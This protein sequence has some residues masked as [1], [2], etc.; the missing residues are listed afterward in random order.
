[1]I[2]ESHKDLIFSKFWSLIAD[3]WIANHRNHIVQVCAD[4]V[5]M[6]IVLKYFYLHELPCMDA[7]R[8]ERLLNN[9]LRSQRQ[10]R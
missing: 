10:F 9:V 1:M 6:E 3:F 7:F 4:A 2:N 8:L 5:Q